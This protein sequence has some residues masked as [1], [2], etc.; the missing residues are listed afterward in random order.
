MR[1]RAMVELILA[2]AAGAG[3]VV[4]WLAAS[5]PSVAPPILPGQPETPVVMYSAP[6]VVL[7]LLLAACAG[8]LG[9]VGVARMRRG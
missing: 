8:V 9:V 3:C 6:L 2:V 4:A 1:S 7:A 5:R